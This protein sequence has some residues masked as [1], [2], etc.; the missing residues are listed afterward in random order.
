MLG[1]HS[2]SVALELAYMSEIAGNTPEHVRSSAT[3]MSQQFHL[4]P[5]GGNT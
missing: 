2:D 3:S 4:I 5:L 1:R